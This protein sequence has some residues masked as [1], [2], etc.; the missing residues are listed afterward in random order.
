MSLLL[1][2]DDICVDFAGD[3]KNYK[4]KWVTWSERTCPHQNGK[5]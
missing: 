4:K 3:D 2:C 1:G 5:K